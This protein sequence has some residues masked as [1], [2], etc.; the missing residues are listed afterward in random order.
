MRLIQREFAW[1]GGSG[2]DKASEHNWTPETGLHLGL[3][4]VITR[5]LRSPKWVMPQ[6]FLS[7]NLQQISKAALRQV[8]IVL[9]G[10]S[11]TN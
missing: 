2:N 9:L 1:I 6:T 11:K 5:D 3:H 4:S 10:L 8:W 7:K